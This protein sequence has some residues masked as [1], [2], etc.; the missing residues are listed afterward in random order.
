M[1]AALYTATGMACWMLAACASPRPEPA[2]R[3]TRHRTALE[4]EGLRA[5]NQLVEASPSEIEQARLTKFPSRNGRVSEGRFRVVYHPGKMVGSGLFS[6]T[7]FYALYDR[8]GKL[9]ASAPTRQIAPDNPFDV[10]IS[11]DQRSLL[12]SDDWGDGAAVEALRAAFYLE[13]SGIWRSR[14][15]ELPDFSEDEFDLPGVIGILGD[16]IFYDPHLDG[17]IYRISIKDLKNGFPFPFAI[18]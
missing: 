12:I 7:S 17:K 13:K 8:E 15:V 9:L 6:T 16:R 4:I 3:C 5:T 2:G 18:G 14:C 1:T 10:F 11:P